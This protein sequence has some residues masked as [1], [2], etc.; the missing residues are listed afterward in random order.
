MF[1]TVFLILF[2]VL[3]IQ[4]LLIPIVLCVDT[5]KNQYYIQLQGL[6]KASLE[7][8][9]EEI[10][11]IKLNIFFT[12]YYFYPLRNLGSVK[13]KKIEEEKKKKG[14]KGIGIVQS[15]RIL[16]AFKVKR[17]MVNIDTGSCISNAKLY[18]VF[19]L[20]NYS[21]GTFSINF[22][23]QNRMELRMLSR[24]IYIIKSFINF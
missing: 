17:L 14:K 1:L 5:A 11:R 12:K 7:A 13:T 3:I 19:A 10:L 23:N 20:L 6:A 18:P 8:H 21:V 2:L 24:P 16:K 4:L 22:N 9:E 15:I